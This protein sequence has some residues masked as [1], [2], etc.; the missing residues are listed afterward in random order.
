MSA[1]TL[2]PDRFMCARFNLSA[3]LR[4]LGNPNLTNDPA[5]LAVLLES[6]ERETAEV[7]AAFQERAHTLRSHAS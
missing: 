5:C 3:T 7:I 4:Q 6:L 2:I 1:P